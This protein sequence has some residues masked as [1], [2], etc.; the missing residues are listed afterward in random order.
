MEKRDCPKIKHTGVLRSELAMRRN[1]E[2]GKLCLQE[3]EEKQEEIYKHILQCLKVGEIKDDE[4]REDIE[5]RLFDWAY[6]DFGELE[7]ILK[8]V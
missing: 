4:L 7:E 1:A 3:L 6:N 2:I 8:N 5:E